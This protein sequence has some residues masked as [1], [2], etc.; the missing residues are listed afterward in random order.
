MATRD[1]YV[2]MHLGGDWVPAGLL[3]LRLE[4]NTLVS[5]SFRYGRRY[6][7]RLDALPIDVRALPLRDEAFGTEERF[8]LFMGIRDALPDAWGRSVMERR[9]DRPLREDEILMASP[10]TRVGALAFGS[11][12]AGPERELP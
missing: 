8:E 2:F 5:S 10:D 9:A 12:L 1:V 3:R 11:S 7:D 6:L 4:D